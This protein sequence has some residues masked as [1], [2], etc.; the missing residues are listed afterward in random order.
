MMRRTR[1]TVALLLAFLLLVG[2]FGVV[3]YAPGRVYLFFQRHRIYP[4]PDMERLPTNAE[5]QSVTPEDLLADPRVKKTNTLMLVNADH[6]L[7][8]DYRPML[9]EYRSIELHPDAVTPFK[10]LSE[11]VQ[12]WTREHLLVTDDYRTREEQ[13]KLLSESPEGIAAE[14][15][16]S[17]HEAGLALD[18][19]VKGFGGQSFLKTPAGIYTNLFCARYGFIIRY[20]MGKEALTGISYEPWHLRYVGEPHARLMAKSGLTLEE[21]ID[22]LTLGVWFR[23]DGAL[24]CRTSERGM[25]LPSGVEWERCEISPDN[26]GYY[27][28]TLYPKA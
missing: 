24:V 7:P 19:C 18:V 11:D 17:E 25:T 27:V 16:C 12:R 28:L 20:P 9:T 5:Y 13:E 10:A 26:L 22:L 14:V 1:R 15:G 21:Y 23:I 6:P 8:E 4:A 3:L 2:A